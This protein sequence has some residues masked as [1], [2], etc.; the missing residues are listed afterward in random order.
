M[1]IEEL[2]DTLTIDGPLTTV[3]QV[4]ERLMSHN[5]YDLIFS[6]VRLGNHNVFEA[7]EEVKPNSLIIFTTAYEDYSYK[8][9]RTN[10]IDYLLKPFSID[11]VQEAMLK[12]QLASRTLS[13]NDGSALAPDTD[14]VQERFLVSRGDT[15]VPVHVDQISCFRKDNDKVRLI[16]A[17]G[18]QYDICC[19][20]GELERKLDPKKFFR[21]NRQYIANGDH[22]SKISLY[23]NS[24]LK[25]SI[26]GCDDESIIVGKE[27]SSQLKKWLNR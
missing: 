7:F 22:I 20:L 27:R 18:E 3:A 23:Y 11:D 9:I 5:D 16:T 10:G 2:D 14:E 19:S 26:A 12:V 24:K 13:A 21:V 8:A 15:L 4:K 1:M 17:T 6:D 25:L